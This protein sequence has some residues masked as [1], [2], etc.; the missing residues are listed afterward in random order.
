MPSLKFPTPT[1]V[2]KFVPYRV[3]VSGCKKLG[4]THT[5]YDFFFSKRDLNRCKLVI[6]LAQ[7]S[8]CTW[9]HSSLQSVV[10]RACELSVE[11]VTFL[12]QASRRDDERY[13]SYQI[14]T[15]VMS[16]LSFMFMVCDLYGLSGRI[17][18]CVM[19]WKEAVF[20]YCTYYL[21]VCLVGLK[22][23][24]IITDLRVEI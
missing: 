5:F 21:T 7:D 22:E 16:F 8:H 4:D 15:R 17:W 3:R 11:C 20:I 19:I 12:G 18:L 24:V 2:V 6:S 1:Y 14:R 10:R 23:I 9:H 13:L